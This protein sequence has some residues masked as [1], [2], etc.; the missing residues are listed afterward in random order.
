MGR[1]HIGYETLLARTRNNGMLQ[2]KKEERHFLGQDALLR[3][4]T[5]R[6]KGVLSGRLGHRNHSSSCSDTQGL[7]EGYV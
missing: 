2:L 5:P 4:I 7:S 3:Y 1:R 6:D